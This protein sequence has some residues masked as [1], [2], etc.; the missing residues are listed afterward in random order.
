MLSTDIISDNA[1]DHRG[2]SLVGIELFTEYNPSI[3]SGMQQEPVPDCIK[4]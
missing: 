4:R 1:N 3:D 2:G